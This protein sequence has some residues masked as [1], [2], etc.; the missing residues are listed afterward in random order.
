[1]SNRRKTPT[2]QQRRVH[3]TL[4]TQLRVC[5]AIV[6]RDHNLVCML[7]FKHSQ[8]PPDHPDVVHVAIALTI[9]KAVVV[10]YRQG[11]GDPKWQAVEQVE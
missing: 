5:G 1:M 2:T 11:K 3:P 10:V 6:D 4:G 7:P 8:L 9:D